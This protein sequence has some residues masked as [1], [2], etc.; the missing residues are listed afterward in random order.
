[1]DVVV[2]LH[3]KALITF[4]ILFRYLKLMRA[5]QSTYLL[6]PAGSRG[7][8]G[9]DDYQFLPFIFGA[10]QLIGVAVNLI[11]FLISSVCG[12]SLCVTVCV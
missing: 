11:F 2:A 6:E 10:A 9:L 4:K 12:D 5:V 8:W 7:V 3:E 1:V